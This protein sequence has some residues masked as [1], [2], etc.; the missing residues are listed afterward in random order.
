MANRSDRLTNC[1]VGKQRLGWALEQEHQT[2][3]E[4][5]HD[6][7]RADFVQNFEE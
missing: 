4:R 7:D 2:S 1:G 6:A 3:G 5:T